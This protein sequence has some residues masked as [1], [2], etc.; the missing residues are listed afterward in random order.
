MSIF[1]NK[2]LKECEVYLGVGAKRFLDRQIEDHL[3]KKP[4]EVDSLDK[5]NMAKW[6]GI[7]A[8]LV[9]GGETGKI[10]SKKIIALDSK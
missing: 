1:Y 2:V 3:F 5:M 6:I 7:S 8:S 10:L 4:E 9:L